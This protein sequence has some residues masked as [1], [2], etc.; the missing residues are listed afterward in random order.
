MATT[1][2]IL[3]IPPSTAAVAV[4]GPS[5]TTNSRTT[6]TL[7]HT[8]FIFSYMRRG[9]N[10]NNN[11]NTKKGTTSTTLN[12]DTAAVTTSTGTTT[13]VSSSDATTTGTGTVT[14]PTTT[15]NTNTT[16]TTTTTNTGYE[17]SIKVIANH[18][19]TIED[20]WYM[21]NYMKR[22]NELPPNIDYHCFRYYDNIPIK[23]TWEDVR[24][25]IHL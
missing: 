11:N 10:N 19:A 4:S 25:C 7:L 20:F 21:Y 2:T 23:P 22:P 13:A 12:N 5:T 3:P 14:N 6:G 8:P 15:T 9:G 18:I 16:N 17:T 1:S 24:M